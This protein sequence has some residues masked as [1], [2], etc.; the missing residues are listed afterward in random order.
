[1][2]CA[3]L[4]QKV[5]EHQDLAQKRVVIL[6]SKIAK[7]IVRSDMIKGSPGQQY[8]RVREDQFNGC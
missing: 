3:F 8:V 4:S 1:M 2:S 5:I 6:R 7:D